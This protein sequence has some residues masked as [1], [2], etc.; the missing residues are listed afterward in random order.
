MED[1]YSISIYTTLIKRE[2]VTIVCNT[3][4]GTFLKLPTECWENIEKYIAVYSPKEICDAAQS[5]DKDYYEKIF[6]L[7]IEKK[8][9]TKEKET[10][11]T[12]DVSLTNR[13]NL[14]CM[15]CAASA[16]KVSDKENLTTTQWKTIMDKIILAQ[17][18]L[19]VLTGGEP[20]VRTDLKKL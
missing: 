18:N 11:D 13:C 14:Q 12:I 16:K 9:L 19:I 3:G 17:P 2:Q 1:K 5:E 15:H 8:I 4:W 10:I 6:S 20:L 7:L